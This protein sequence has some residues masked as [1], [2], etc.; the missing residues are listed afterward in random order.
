[1]RRPSGDHVARVNLDRRSGGTTTLARSPSIVMT[2]ISHDVPHHRESDAGSL[3]PECF[4][5]RAAHERIEDL[6]LL[7][8]RNAEAAIAH[9]DRHAR[10]VRLHLDPDGPALRRGVHRA[11]EA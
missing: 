4:G 10:W 2:R 3:D 11:L 1:M 7:A 8:E 9:G 6:L 5:L